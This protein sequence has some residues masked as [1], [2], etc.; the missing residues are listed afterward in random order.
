VKPSITSI[1]TSP[2]ASEINDVKQNLDSD[3]YDD[4][5][6]SLKI[7]ETSAQI[8]DNT[9][10]KLYHVFMIIIYSSFCIIINTNQLN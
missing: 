1:I 10:S 4:E 2:I 5:K 9:A 6:I 8:P 3:Y 7:K